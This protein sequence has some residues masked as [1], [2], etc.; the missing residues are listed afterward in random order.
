MTDSPKGDPKGGRAYWQRP[1][2][3]FF[4]SVIAGYAFFTWAKERPEVRMPIVMLFVMFWTGL[5]L[6]TFLWWW[7]LG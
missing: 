5:L 2:W 3:Q 1:F 7:V 6:V 4:L